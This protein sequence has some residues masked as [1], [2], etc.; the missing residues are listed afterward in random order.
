[1]HSFGCVPCIEQQVEY[2]RAA[3]KSLGAEFTTEGSFRGK[4]VAR[5]VLQGSDEIILRHRLSG[6]WG[7]LLGCSES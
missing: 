2:R 1:M 4:T 7:L 6:C 3:C 5:G